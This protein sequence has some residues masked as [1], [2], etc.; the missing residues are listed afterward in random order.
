MTGEEFRNARLKA[1]LTLK[2]TAEILG[3]YINTIQKYEA[4][5]IKEIPK[6]TS[7]YFLIFTNQHNKF[8]LKNDSN[9][10]KK[11]LTEYHN[12]V[13]EYASAMPPEEW[14]KKVKRLVK[15]QN[16]EEDKEMDLWNESLYVVS[17]D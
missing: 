1:G 6:C 10:A 16:L 4:N 9:E 17:A 12:F 5:K 15:N 14:V 13:G 8:G 2:E 3:L 7:E 11:L